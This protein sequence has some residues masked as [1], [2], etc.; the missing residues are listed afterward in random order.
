LFALGACAT[1]IRGR[2]EPDVVFTKYSS[3]SQPTEIAR[4]ALSPITYRRAEDDL[5]ARNQRLADQVIDLAKEKFDIY[6]PS[7]QPPPGGYGLLVY[8]APWDEPT[9]P[10]DWYSALESHK[11][12][13][14]A[15]QDSGNAKSVLNRRIPLAILAYENVRARF[16]LNSQR[17]FIAG[18]SGGS[19]VAA[20]VALAYPDVFRGVI[21]NA[22]SDAIDGSMHGEGNFKPPTELFRAFQ[23]SRLVYVTGEDDRD[24][25][26]QDKLSRESMRDNCVLDIRDVLEPHVAHLAVD[27]AV[28]DRALDA[29]DAPAA[30]DADELARCNERV[31]SKVTDALGKVSTAI[32]RGDREGARTQ[33]MAI[34]ARYGG[35][36]APR[37]VELYAKLAAMK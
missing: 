31:E 1:T 30:I 7:E 9:R 6:V 28:L 37:S 5:A 10:K 35:L 2:P 29:L 3:L 34:D 26:Q 11:L 17:V 25:V 24:H 12:I 20:M 33:L 19:R 32:A 13:F 36:A 27:G 22:G 4:R 8:V 21:M 16:P 18:F 15:A 23:R 14:V